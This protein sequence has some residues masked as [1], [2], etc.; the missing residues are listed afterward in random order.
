[1]GSEMCIRDRNLK[2]SCKVF[3]KKANFSFSLIPQKTYT[4]W[5]DYDIIK[6]SLLIRTRQQGDRIVIDKKGS[7]Q[8]LKNYLINEKVPEEKRG[9]LLLIADGQQIIWIPGMRQSH[10]YQVK[11]E[12]KRIL[13]IR[14]TEEKTDVRDDP[15]VNI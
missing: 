13:E 14:I 15:S 7:T 10:A 11:E 3:K 6:N 9:S 5:F 12:T 8:K 2:V 4:K 1:M